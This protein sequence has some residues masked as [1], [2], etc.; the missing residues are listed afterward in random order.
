MK[1]GQWLSKALLGN[2]LG[3]LGTTRGQF[4]LPLCNSRT[5]REHPAPARG[6]ATQLARD[7]G[8]IATQRPGDLADPKPG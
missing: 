8:R 5:V 7:R 2:K 4:R 6:V 3:G 1:I